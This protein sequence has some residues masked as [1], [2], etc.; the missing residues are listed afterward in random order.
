MDG[1]RVYFDKNGDSPARYELV[2]LQI[3]NKGTMEGE[4]V[5]IFDTSLQDDNQFIFNN[6]SVVWGNGLTK[7]RNKSIILG[8]VHN[9]CVLFCILICFYLFIVQI[10]NN[11]LSV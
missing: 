5:G 10:Q 8:H 6:I 11:H 9:F 2:N 3:T 4:T 7:V 1:E